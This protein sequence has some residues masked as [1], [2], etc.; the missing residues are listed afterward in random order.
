MDELD[1]FAYSHKENSHPLRDK[2]TN[3]AKVEA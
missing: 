2:K 3:E 1:S